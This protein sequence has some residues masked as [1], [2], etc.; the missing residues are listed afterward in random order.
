LAKST[1]AARSSLALKAA[2]AFACA[3]CSAS[4]T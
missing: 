4:L 1:S 2:S 3:I